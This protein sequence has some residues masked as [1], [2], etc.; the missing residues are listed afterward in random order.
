M[1][2][3]VAAL[4]ELIAHLERQPEERFNMASVKFE[5]H[6]C[7]TAACIAGHGMLIFGLNG[8]RHVQYKL[9]LPYDAYW[10]LFMPDGFDVETE[11]VR[12]YPLSR[13]IA[14]LKRLRDRFL[15]TGEIVVD[16][17]PEPGQEPRKTWAAP[18]VS[19][20]LPA[21]ITA[22]LDGSFPLTVEADHVG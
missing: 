19:G 6:A 2:L 7:G 13:A 4:N 3:N 14:T 9:G 10:P 5:K 12:R 15:A 17:G 11:S 21:S 16:W 8:S 1:S 20:G 18:V 22:A